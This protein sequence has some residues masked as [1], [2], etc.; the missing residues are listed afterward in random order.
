M[1]STDNTVDRMSPAA[2]SSAFPAGAVDKLGP[3]VREWFND[4]N[5]QT[6]SGALAFVPF[7]L[8]QSYFDVQADQDQIV[9]HKGAGAVVF[10]DVSG[11]TA[12]TE[13]LAKSANGAELLSACLTA[14][15]YTTHRPDQRVPR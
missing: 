2:H 11:F 13:K 6:L 1:R 14:F 8:Q 4:Q 15:F 9:V 5:G 3:N 10:S 7:I 12:L